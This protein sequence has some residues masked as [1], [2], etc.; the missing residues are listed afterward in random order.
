MTCSYWQLLRCAAALLVPKPHLTSLNHPFSAYITQPWIEHCSVC[1]GLIFTY[2]TSSSEAFRQRCYT[3]LRALW[4]AAALSGLL[5]SSLTQAGEQFGEP[6]TACMQC[7][8]ALHLLPAP[9]VTVSPT[10]A[11][12]TAAAAAAAAA[13]AKG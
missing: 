2:A 1:A 13:A 10:P 8:A 4:L 9:A 12:A 5:C 3:P 11:A 6:A 7:T